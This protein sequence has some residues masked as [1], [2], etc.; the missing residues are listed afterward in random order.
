MFFGGSGQVC[1]LMLECICYRMLASNTN[2]TIRRAYLLA[3]LC[4]LEFACAVT[5][6]WK[7]RW[8]WQWW[9]RM[10][11]G[12]RIMPEAKQKRVFKYRR[13]TLLHCEKS[14]NVR[15]PYNHNNNEYNNIV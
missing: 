2:L 9:R 12:G 13:I 7:D 10:L 8:R 4:N 6:P 1:S 11:H 14:A 5:A 3:I 15:V